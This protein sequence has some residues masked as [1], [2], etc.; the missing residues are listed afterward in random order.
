MPASEWLLRL[1]GRK[2]EA[3]LR[4][5]RQHWNE[6]VAE[7]ARRGGGYRESGCFLLGRRADGTGRVDRIVYFD[8]LDPNCL[9]GAISFDGAA[10]EPLWSTCRSAGLRVVADAHTH[11][12]SG[13]GQSTIDRANPMIAQAGHIGI[14]LPNFGQGDIHPRNVG[15]HEYLGDEG[16]RSRF[17]K[18]ADSR[19]YV[20]RRP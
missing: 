19:I 20:G 16:W 4:F 12:G 11:P 5:S 2:P 6:M 17:G 15:V 14:I 7:L 1:L 10:F 13:V 9:Q 3:Q 8:D 18:Q